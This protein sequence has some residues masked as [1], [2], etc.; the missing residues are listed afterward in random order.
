MEA[1]LIS[2]LSQSVD[3]LQKITGFVVAIGTFVSVWISTRSTQ[4]LKDGMHDKAGTKRKFNDAR[5]QKQAEL[6]DDLHSFNIRYRL[7]IHTAKAMVDI[8]L[9]A[10]MYDINLHDARKARPHF[11]PNT[12]ELHVPG[13]GPPWRRK[14]A[15]FSVLIVA[16]VGLSAA[17]NPFAL[18][19][20]NKTQT[21]MW[22]TNEAAYS[23]L[24]SL[25]ANDSWKLDRHLCLLVKSKYPLQDPWDKQVACSLISGRHDDYIGS[26]VTAQ[27]FGGLCMIVMASTAGLGYWEDRRRVRFARH[28][29]AKLDAALA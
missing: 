17:I 22:V 23:A 20:V 25:S 11:R 7:G 12:L 27:R 24:D 14:M 10:Q 2:S 28:L 15:I 5:L 29:R 3:A 4:V 9:W 6:E 1:N 18:I 21:R 19:T 26:A 13:D 16:V 8:H